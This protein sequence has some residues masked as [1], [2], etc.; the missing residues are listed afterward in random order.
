MFWLFRIGLNGV[1]PT[2]AKQH[3]NT[4]RVFQNQFFS[5]LFASCIVWN[6]YKTVYV[7]TSRYNVKTNKLAGSWIDQTVKY[8]SK[9]LN[10]SICKNSIS[11]QNQLHACLC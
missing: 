1:W 7:V 8:N 11:H 9:P 5:Q 6:K 10:N 4:I 2:S 3:S